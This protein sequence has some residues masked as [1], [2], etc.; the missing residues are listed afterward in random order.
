MLHRLLAL[1]VCSLCQPPAAVPVL[2]LPPLEACVAGCRS[3]L[4]N[5]VQM[6]PGFAY[7]TVL[8]MVAHRH[9]PLGTL[10]DIRFGGRVAHGIVLDNLVTNRQLGVELSPAIFR[11]LG[12]LQD[13]IQPVT[14][15]VVGYEPR[16]RWI[17]AIG[18]LTP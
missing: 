8:P 3:H 18:A 13:G 17:H 2:P 4:F 11:S 7:A 12:V 14:L 16:S 5:G 10:V 9:L 6:A 15:E 1:V